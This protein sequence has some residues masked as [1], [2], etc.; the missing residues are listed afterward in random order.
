MPLTKTTVIDIIDDVLQVSAGT[1]EIG[2][3]ENISGDY[4]SLL[5]IDAGAVDTNAQDGMDIVVEISY[6]TENWIEFTTFK[7]TPGTADTTTLNGGEP[8][9]ETAI[10]LTSAT[11]F[12]IS[13]TLL[14]IE[15]GADSELV[16]TLGIASGQTIT[17]ASG[18]L[19]T[20]ADTTS[21]FNLA[22]HWAIELPFAASQVRVLYNNTDAN[23][24]MFVTTRISKV[25]DL[26]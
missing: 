2:N 23:S 1:I 20:H 9:G 19:N 6:G 21:I 18:L 11:D 22:N 10:V 25:T 26:G 4:S 16:R 7:S 3:A 14:Y 12:D 5:Y 8:Q 15:D 17:I 13:G 24:D